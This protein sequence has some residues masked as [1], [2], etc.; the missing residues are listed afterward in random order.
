VRLRTA[1]IATP[2]LA[3]ALAGGYFGWLRDSGLVAVNDVSI[4]G[5]GSSEREGIEAALTQA[6]SGMTT[7]NVDEGELEEAVAGF[8]T[9]VGVSVDPQLLHGLAIEVTERAPAVIVES[10]SE[11]VPAAG[12]GVLLR[13]LELSDDARVGLPGLAVEELPGSGRLA[14]EPLAQATVAGAAP[15]PLRPLIEELSFD[16]EQ[17]VEVTMKGGIPIRFGDAT[18]AA[19]KWAAAAAVLADPQLET[20]TYID[21][22]VPGRPAVGGAAAPTAQEPA[23]APVDPTL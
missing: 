5:V 14:G 16:G 1:L 11:S 12:D 6:T 22:R 18:G 9:V 19:A 3:A 20:L 21:V 15:K 13:G 7:L 8:P 17:G 4:T 23:P 2:L 10:G